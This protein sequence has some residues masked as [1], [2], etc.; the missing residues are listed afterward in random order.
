M[1]NKS[2][3]ISYTEDN[4]NHTKLQYNFLAEDI[5]NP[6]AK[7][8]VLMLPATKGKPI[9]SYV[10]DCDKLIGIIKSTL[11]FRIPY[12]CYIGPNPTY[13]YSDKSKYIHKLGCLYVDIDAH[14]N[15]NYEN[16]EHEEMYDDN[17]I[18]TQRALDNFLLYL[19]DEFFGIKV[20]HPSM[21][22]R[23][24]RGFQLYWKLHPASYN[25]KM[26][27]FW[28]NIERNLIKLFRDIS[29][30][31]FEID[32]TVCNAN[33]VLRIAG[34]FN[35]SSETYTTV[36]YIGPEKYTLTEM[37]EWVFGGVT[38]GKKW[39]NYKKK[40][41]T[42]RP[43]VTDEY[44]ARKNEVRLGMLRNR[45]D[46]LIRLIY[47]RD[48]KMI[49]YRQTTLYLALCILCDL[50]YT[51][52]EK[53]CALQELNNLFAEPLESKKVIKLSK[54]Y[55]RKNFESEKIIEWLNISEEEQLNL[56]TI[57]NPTIRKN[58]R[59]AKK[60]NIRSE[61][62]K[63]RLEQVKTFKDSGMTQREIAN[64]MGINIRTVKNYYK[65][66]RNLNT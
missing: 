8:R 25:R 23:T 9:T 42:I 4:L 64:E 22:V 24:G 15:E 61:R 45:L 3:L 39:V 34:T 63:Q 54:R 19:E 20:P 44:K 29:F 66:I 52:D 2:S 10:S 38:T 1:D 43:I 11:N 56:K 62:T 5:T 31:D 28:N 37:S 36:D 48:G 16:N 47:L 7:F 53:L 49:G 13:T 35:Y 46:D 32:A 41:R 26:I 27:V 40:K 33:R 18:P 55:E 30:G 6:I 51:E 65:K 57:V 21:I 14:C 59:D 58:R 50:K 60:K 12:N 17:G